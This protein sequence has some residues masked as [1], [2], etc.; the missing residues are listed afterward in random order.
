[1]TKITQLKGMLDQYAKDKPRRWHSFAY[2]RADGVYIEKEKVVVTIGFQ[3]RESWQDLGS[4][5]FDKAELKC[6]CYEASKKLGIDYDELPKRELLY[7][8]GVLKSGKADQYRKSLH[9][10]ENIQDPPGDTDLKAQK[11]VLGDSWEEKDPNA[12]FLA[13][14]RRSH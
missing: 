14:L 12:Q 1:M 13:Q 9:S 4:I 10:P 8:A 6:F 2:C 5:L 11:S 7:Y 3:H